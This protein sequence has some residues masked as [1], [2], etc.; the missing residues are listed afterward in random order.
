MWLDPV[1]KTNLFSLMNTKNKTVFF[2]F[3]LFTLCITPTLNIKLQI[4]LNVYLIISYRMIFHD[5]FKCWFGVSASCY[6]ERAGMESEKYSFW[7]NEVEEEQL[8]PNF[9]KALNSF[10]ENSV[11]RHLN[12]DNTV[13]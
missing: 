2:I 12:I 7:G 8:C 13:N 6:R 10:F 9:Y 5:T 1:P 3:L 11:L 4:K